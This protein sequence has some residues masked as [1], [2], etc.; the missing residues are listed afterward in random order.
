MGDKRKVM[1]PVT[2][3]LLISDYELL[4][5]II[6]INLEAYFNCNLD[7]I[8]EI[9]QLEICI[10]RKHYNIIISLASIGNISITEIINQT[11]RTYLPDTDLIF[12]GEQSSTTHKKTYHI[13]RYNDISALNNYLSII[14]HTPISL[15]AV[16][17][18]A[19]WFS[20]PVELL[21]LTTIARQDLWMKNS[22]QKHIVYLKKGEEIKSEILNESIITE[23]ILYIQ[24]EYKVFYVMSIT[25]EILNHTSLNFLNKPVVEIHQPHRIISTDNAFDSVYKNACT[26]LNLANYFFERNRLELSKLANSTQQLIDKVSRYLPIEIN[27]LILLYKKGNTQRMQAHSLLCC[28]ISLTIAKSQ[29]WYNPMIH[30]TIELL[31]FFHDLMLTPFEHKYSSLN[32]SIHSLDNFN[33]KAKISENEQQLLLY[34]PKEIAHYFKNIPETPLTLEQL[35]MHHHGNTKGINDNSIQQE[36][37][38]SIAKLFFVADA[39]T[40]ILLSQNNP[41]NQESWI[42]IID[43]IENKLKRTSYKKYTYALRFNQILI[44]N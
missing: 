27:K 43:E 11:A 20:I 18:N 19:E 29:G 2:N 40:D 6:K 28:F 42:M 38:S 9:N 12:L 30:H 32:S 16:T 31:C 44:D 39:V 24:N 21:K 33:V 4:S 17:I 8:S 25:N 36:E 35:L 41:I 23:K 14:L 3:V 13:N 34:H 37:I 26:N 7:V 15:S 10:Q 1:N 22:E 5:L